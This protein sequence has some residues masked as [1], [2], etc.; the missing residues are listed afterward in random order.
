MEGGNFEMSRKTRKLVF[1]KKG[2]EAETLTV[3]VCDFDD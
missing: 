2:E 3:L 1:M